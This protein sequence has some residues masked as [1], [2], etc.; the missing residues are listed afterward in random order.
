MTLRFCGW[1]CSISINCRVSPEA[2]DSIGGVNQ[3]LI[4][5]CYTKY[6]R[7]KINQF[8]NFMSH[9]MI[10]PFKTCFVRLATPVASKPTFVVTF[11][12]LPTVRNVLRDGFE[13]FM[14]TLLIIALKLNIAYCILILLA[15]VKYQNNKFYPIWQKFGINYVEHIILFKFCNCL[16]FVY[17]T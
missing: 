9:F 12:V 15:I 3:T 16:Q 4:S 6:Y 11:V 1:Q 5:Y 13:S 8:I 10:T 17:R 7:L 14:N 2:S